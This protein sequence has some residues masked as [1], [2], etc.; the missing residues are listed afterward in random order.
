V[1]VV[2][3]ARFLALG[4]LGGHAS[5][6]LANVASD[7]PRYLGLTAV[8]VASP[9]ALR[10]DEAGNAASFGLAAITAITLTLAAVRV[11]RAGNEATLDPSARAELTTGILGLLWILGLAAVYAVTGLLQPWHLF[12]PGLGLALAVGAVAQG[13]ARPRTG[14]RRP[15]ATAGLLLLLVWVLGIARFSPIFIGYGHWQRGA[16]V[17]RNYLEPLAQRIE[18]APDGSLI[19]VAPPQAV[20]TA[21]PSPVA[22]PAATLLNAYALPA[23]AE[24]HFPDRRIEFRSLRAGEP[25]PAPEPGRLLIAVRAT[26]RR[27]PQSGSSSS[28]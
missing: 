8:R 25:L 22:A 15:A 17:V 28:R 14:S 5:T 9:V 19:E 3:A 1:A 27:T 7:L 4:E 24:L 12:L 10:F 11:V 21:D 2:F 23:W 16:V 6:N 26:A 20:A 13:L 18:R